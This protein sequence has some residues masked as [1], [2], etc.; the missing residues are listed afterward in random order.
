MTGESGWG[1]YLLHQQ[2]L[3]ADGRAIGIARYGRSY[4]ESAVF[5]QQAG[6]HFPQAVIPSFGLMVIAATIGWLGYKKQMNW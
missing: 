2:E 3:S 5:E 4:N 6:A 1:F